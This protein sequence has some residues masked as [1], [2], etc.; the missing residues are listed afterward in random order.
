MIQKWLVVV[1]LAC[2]VAGSRMVGEINFLTG[3]V[4]MIIVCVLVGVGIGMLI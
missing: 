4:I 1:Y 2:L 3:I